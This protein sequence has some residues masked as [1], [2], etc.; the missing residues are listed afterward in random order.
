[1]A[2]TRKRLSAAAIATFALALALTAIT[3]DAQAQFGM[4]MGMGM[5]RGPM[6]MGMRG[7]MGMGSARSMMVDGPGYGSRRSHRSRDYDDDPPPRHAK[8]GK[9]PATSAP[10][11]AARHV[12]P[13]KPQPQVQP[14]IVSKPVT[15]SA[16]AVQSAPATQQHNPAPV[17]ASQPAATS[18]TTQ[19]DADSALPVRLT[20]QTR[21]LNCMTKLHLKDGTV[22]LQD[23]CT[24]EQAVIKQGETS[25]AQTQPPSPPAQK[26]HEQAPAQIARNR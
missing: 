4:G 22:I 20:P 23:F 3:S 13:A 7:P 11:A 9:A 15:A 2:A 26:Q 12:A 25:Q 19:S 17:I 6:G 8:R 14:A 10:V 5:M 21:P 18:T 1:M 24:L 16:P